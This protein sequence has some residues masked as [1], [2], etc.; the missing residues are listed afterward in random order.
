MRK[1]LNDLAANQLGLAD[2]PDF[3]IIN[4]TPS[5]VRKFHSASRPLSGA[6]MFFYRGLF[7][8][9]TALTKGDAVAEVAWMTRSQLRE[10]LPCEAWEAANEVLPLDEAFL[11]GLIESEAC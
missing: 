7:G 3:H 11:K 8:G 10:A 5:F 2:H 9:S 1:T 6:K 4:Y